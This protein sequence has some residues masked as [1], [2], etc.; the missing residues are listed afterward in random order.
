MWLLLISLTVVSCCY[1]VTTKISMMALLAY[2]IK[3]KH[4][5]LDNIP[6]DKV[7]KYR[8]RAVRELFRLR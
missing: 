8:N 6:K 7:I 5:D 2:L 1:A 4:V 3:E